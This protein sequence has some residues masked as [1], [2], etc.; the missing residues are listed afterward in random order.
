VGGHAYGWVYPGPIG[1]VVTPM[2]TGLKESKMLPQASSLCGACREACPVKINIPRML[3]ELRHR[4]AESDDP[5]EQA[6]SG[7]ERFLAGAYARLMSS[8]GR[9]ALAA[10]MGRIAQKLMPGMPKRRGWIG[11]TRL[12]LLGKWT[13]E[14]DLP[15]LPS[16]SF[17]E[18]WRDELKGDDTPRGN[19][20]RR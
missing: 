5:Q 10:R 2:L 18:I 11:G 7:S 6:S 19:S 15:M 8:P 16:K 9:M 17:R 12:P 1:A 14:R 4:T 20:G 3:L 13:K